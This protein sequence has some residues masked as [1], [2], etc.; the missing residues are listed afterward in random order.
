MKEKKKYCDNLHFIPGKSII[1]CGG[2]LRV[3]NK[4]TMGNTMGITKIFV[5]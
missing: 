2:H 4:T 3:Y 5:N 1:T